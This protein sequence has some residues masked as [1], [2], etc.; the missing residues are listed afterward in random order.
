MAMKLP[1]QVGEFHHI[2]RLCAVD[3]PPGAVEAAAS[4]RPDWKRATGAVR[5]ER[6]S[7]HQASRAGRPACT[8][9]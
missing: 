9:V 5:A 1:A 3:A 7:A 4:Y 8:L 6:R 2:S